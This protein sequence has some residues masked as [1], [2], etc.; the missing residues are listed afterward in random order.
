L[1]FSA[2]LERA[3][4][5]ITGEGCLDASSFRGKVVGSVLARAARAEVSAFV[6]VG[7]IKDDAGAG[8]DVVSLSE[9]FSER[10]SYEHTTSSVTHAVLA[11]LSQSEEPQEPAPAVFRWKRQRR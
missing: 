4:L 2:E 3:D 10:R 7:Q 6:V 11:R 1:G 8:H 5:V 9:A